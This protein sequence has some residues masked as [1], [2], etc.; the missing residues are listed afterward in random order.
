MTCFLAS[1]DHEEFVVK[2]YIDTVFIISSC[3]FRFKLRIL[4]NT[5]YG[6]TVSW[7]LFQTSYCGEFYNRGEV[8]CRFRSDK[9]NVESCSSFMNLVWFQEGFGQWDTIADSCSIAQSEESRFDLWFTYI[10]SQVHTKYAFCESVKM[11]RYV[12]IHTELK[13]SDPLDIRLYHMQSIFYTS[14]PWV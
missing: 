8:C 2:C 6:G 9:E 5:Q 14:V 3:D 12:N 13:S 11:R 4:C 7:K 1:R 10:H